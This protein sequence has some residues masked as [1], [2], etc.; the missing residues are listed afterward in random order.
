MCHCL[1]AGGV[2]DLAV[3]LSSRFRSGTIWPSLHDVPMRLEGLRVVEWLGPRGRRL[4]F[5]YPPGVTPT[6]FGPNAR[7]RQWNECI[8]VTLALRG[9]L[10]RRDSCYASAKARFGPNARSRQWN[11]SVDV[12]LVRRVRCL[13]LVIGVRA[14]L[15]L[16]YDLHLMA[17]CTDPA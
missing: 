17:R 5:G 1:A 15:P 13:R 6:R 9:R 8:D 14:A 16:R 4:R 11:E 7:S 2:T 3:R 10:V 12:S